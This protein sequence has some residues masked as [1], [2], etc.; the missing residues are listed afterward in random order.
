MRPT[1]PTPTVRRPPPRLSDQ[2]GPPPSIIPPKADVDDF[3]LWIIAMGFGA[4]FLWLGLGALLKV[5]QAAR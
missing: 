4:F 5:F 2:R 1:K 3:I